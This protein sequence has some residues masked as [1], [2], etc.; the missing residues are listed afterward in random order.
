MD[1][2]KYVVGGAI[3]LV[4]L[5]ALTPVIMGHYDSAQVTSTLYEDV[6]TS[7]DWNA[8]LQDGQTGYSISNGELTV[9]NDTTILTKNVNTSSFE[10]DRLVV[11]ATGV[12]GTMDVAIV[13]GTS[14]TLDT[15]SLTDNETKEVE[16]GSYSADEYHLE[17]DSGTDGDAV[18]TSYTVNGESDVDQTIQAVMLMVLITFF[19]AV[20]YRAYKET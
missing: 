10:D 7:D 6:T 11:E 20:A 16:L 19:L 2:V 12:S 4:F 15:I 18:V 13:D 9:T 8:S 17:F 1:S 14:T 3:A 5:F